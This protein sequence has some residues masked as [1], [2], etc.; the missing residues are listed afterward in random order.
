M[1][2][3]GLR[4]FLTKYVD[5]FFPGMATAESLDSDPLVGPTRNTPTLLRQAFARRPRKVKSRRPL[6][7]PHQL[8]AFH[9][10][11]YWRGPNDMVRQMMLGLRGT[12]AEV[13]EYNTDEHREALD[14]EGRPYDRGTFGPVWLRW[15]VLREEVLSFRPHL[16]ICNAGGLSFRPEVA[17]DLRRH[18]RLLGIVLSDPDVFELTTRHIA[19]NFDLLLTNAPESIPR[20]AERGV[21]VAQLPIATHEGFFLPMPPRPEY[22]CEVLVLGAEHSDRIE[23]VRSLLKRFDTHVH[24]E[25]WTRHGIVSRGVIYGQDVLSAL[26][27]AR[28]AVIFSRTRAGS[29]VVK[30][31]LFDFIAAGALVA[32]ERF[33][34][35]EQYLEFGR[36]VIGFTSLPEMLEQIEYYLSHPAEAEATRQAGRERVLHQHTWGQVW[37]RLL[38]EMPSS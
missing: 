18:T 5:R 11:G 37:P 22:A 15:E 28:I 3:D 17:G 14:C 33:P 36:E 4:L 19:Q 24:G 27:S 16:I 35:V 13:Y 8:R 6:P 9:I 38:A 10:G 7:P 30:V 29:Q 20:Y 26:N 1:R 12:G 31:G 23:P 34:E 21:R 25:G 2:Q 32:T